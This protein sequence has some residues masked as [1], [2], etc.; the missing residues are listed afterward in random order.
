MA[1]LAENSEGTTSATSGSSVQ[2]SDLAV[3]DVRVRE[4]SADYVRIIS[5]D[6]PMANKYELVVT[7][8]GRASRFLP[9]AADRTAMSPAGT[10]TRSS[11]CT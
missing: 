9:E 4:L 3:L 6:T 8:N 5:T 2:A 7:W 1:V 10:S 11:S